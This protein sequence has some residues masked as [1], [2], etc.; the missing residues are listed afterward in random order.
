MW[1]NYWLV[2]MTKY[3]E[4]MEPYDDGDSCVICRMS[5]EDVIK[6]MKKYQEAFKDHPNYPYKSDQDALD[7]FQ[8]IHWAAI[9][10]DAS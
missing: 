6:S 7:D 8:V 9:V 5:F 1:M 2:D 10:E 3:M 4:W